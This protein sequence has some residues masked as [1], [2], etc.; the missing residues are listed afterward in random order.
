MPGRVQDAVEPVEVRDPV[1]VDLAASS[2]RPLRVVPTEDAGAVGLEADEQLGRGH[3]PDDDRGAVARSGAAVQVGEHLAAA[4]PRA[5]RGSSSHV[6]AQVA[7]Q[8]ARGH[9]VVVEAEATPP[10]GL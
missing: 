8:V 6:G 2:G 4:D 1:E 3:G 5:R 9:L 7:Q 10:G